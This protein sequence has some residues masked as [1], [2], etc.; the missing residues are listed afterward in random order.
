MFYEK[1]YTENVNTKDIDIDTCLQQYNVPK[2]TDEE[3]ERLEGLIKY[4]EA[5][6]SLKNMRN[7]TSPGSDGFSVEFMK[8][9]WNK[10]GYYVV[11]SLNY[12]FDTGELSTTQKEGIITCIPK[13]N[14]PKQFLKNWRPITLLNTVYKI[15]SSSIANRLKSVLDKLISKEQT[16]FMTGRYIGENTRLIYD[17]LQF[18]E[19]KDIPGLLLFIDFEKAFDSVSWKFMEKVLKF[20][21]FGSSLRN[22]IKVLY[23]NIKSRVNIGGHL[24]DFFSPGRGCR[25]GDPVS[26]YL[27]ILCAEILS[28]N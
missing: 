8:M 5:T 6:K 2:L 27:Y 15:G 18:T 12:G 11:R 28:I 21:K 17:I 9:F 25:Q 4:E 1:L 23:N 26:C 22:W 19:E 14:K 20:F 24:S 13:D 7:N 10:I 3:A 16:G